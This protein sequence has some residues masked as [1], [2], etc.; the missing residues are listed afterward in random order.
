MKRD[1]LTI[2]VLSIVILIVWR[3]AIFNFF[4]QDDFILIDH[5]S[6]NNIW[7]D[8][9]NIFGP[10][11]VTH[12]RPIHN[13]YFFI[14]GNLFGKT[15]FLY[16]FLTLL[17]VVGTGFLIYKIAQKVWGDFNVALL[18]ALIYVIH[19]AH[20]VAVFWIAGSALNIGFFFFLLSFYLLLQQKIIL[21][22]FFYFVSLLASEAMIAA[23]PIFIFGPLFKKVRLL[24]NYTG[25]IILTTIVFLTIKL[26]NTPQ[27]TFDIY[28][29]E[30]STK[31]IFAMRYYI[32]RTLGFAEPSGD[33]FL[34]T[35]MAV[36]LIA[37]FLKIFRIKKESRKMVFPLLT[38]GGFS[39]FI[40]LPNH[41]SPHY[42]VLPVFGISQLLALGLSKLDKKLMIGGFLLLMLISF[43]NINIT[44]NNNW[45]I[46]RSN[47]AKGHLH[48]IEKQNLPDGST[49][50][51]DETE[52]STSEEAY[53]SLGTG[54]AIKFWFKDRNY[55]TC[56]TRFEKCSPLP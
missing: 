51:F 38:F 16:H 18:S 48:R 49:L 31:T 20:F 13:L 33:L 42:M 55:K 45:V 5:F 6:Q 39:P 26:V 19:P 46:K 56:F 22:I 11:A 1:L 43:F 44:T 50:V 21:S 4:A 29:L 35:V 52:I 41:L 34:S 23:L 10:P 27:A 54:E 36:V 7:Q 24:S 28:K 8:I 47:L 9:K 2:F 14:S 15:Y 12:W 32:L 3:S 25:A 53:I 40:L 17:I 37:I 30:I